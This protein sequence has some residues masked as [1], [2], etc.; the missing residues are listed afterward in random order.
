[1]LRLLVLLLIPLVLFPRCAGA[2]AASGDLERL[3]RQVRQLD[4]RDPAV[5]DLARQTLMTLRR[6]DLPLLQK[7]VQSVGTISPEQ[8]NSLEDV[9]V[10]V[11]IAGSRLPSEQSGF[12]GVEL[13]MPGFGPDGELL[14]DEQGALILNRMPG[15]AAYEVLQDGELIV[16]IEQFPNDPIRNGDDLRRVISSFRAGEAVTLMV[17]RGGQIERRRVLLSARPLLAQQGP[18]MQLLADRVAEAEAFFDREFAPLIAVA[19]S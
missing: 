16:G 15:F 14:L 7:A 5:R 3:R 10:H 12:L 19:G 2:Q 18:L 17:Q 8:L 1:M 11:H 9:V 13:A 4:D 6:V